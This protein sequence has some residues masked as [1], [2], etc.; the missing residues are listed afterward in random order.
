MAKNLFDFADE[1]G[2]IDMQSDTY[3]KGVDEEYLKRKI[4]QYSAM[5]QKD[6]MGALLNEVQSS[7][8]NGSFDYN[9]I[10]SS[11][12]LVRDYLTPEQQK[13]LEQLLNKIK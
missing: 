7:K 10:S 12:E 5:S 4:D 3:E 13:N 8:R 1:N 9:K 2:K 11:L 6:M